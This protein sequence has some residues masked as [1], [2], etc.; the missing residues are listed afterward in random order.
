MLDFSS[1]NDTYLREAFLD[2]KATISDWD[3]MTTKAFLR[4]CFLVNKH[5]CVTITEIHLIYNHWAAE[6][7]MPMPSWRYIGQSLNE[8][9]LPLLALFSAD[10]QNLD[11]VVPFIGG[12]APKPEYQID[13]TTINAEDNNERKGDQNMKQGHRVNPQTH[14]AHFV[15]EDHP[16]QCIAF[17]NGNTLDCR[18][19][20]L[21]WFDLS[22]VQQHYPDQLYIIHPEDIVDDEDILADAE[23]E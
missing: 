6:Q 1:D 4:D 13:F 18:D 22:W 9:D 3:R 15:S 7:Q 8:L 2:T 21:A 20:N 23:D 12:L 5:Y 19:D 11:D 10:T 14:F 16:N 17:L